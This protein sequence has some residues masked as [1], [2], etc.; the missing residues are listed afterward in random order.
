MVRSILAGY[1]TQTRRVVKPKPP[2]WATGAKFCNEGWGTDRKH[3]WCFNDDAAFESFTSNCPYGQPADH[4]WVR[5]TFYW[6][7]FEKLTASKPRDFERDL[8]YRA[9]GECCDQIPECQ[10]AS[11]GKVEWSPSIFMRRWASRITLEIV[12][13]R[14]ER[15]KAISEEDANAEGVEPYGPDDGRYKEGYKELFESINGKGSWKAN[16]WVWVVTFKQVFNE[17][18]QR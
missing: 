6:D 4:L 2:G 15:L 1:K 17:K 11:E 16:P 7:R 10:C 3:K 13:V 9:D 18:G 8:Y 5:E 12:D 14:V